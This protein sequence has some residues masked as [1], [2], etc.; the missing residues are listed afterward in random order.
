[1]AR[2]LQLRLWLKE[3]LNHSVRFP[4]LVKTPS[5]RHLNSLFSL[6]FEDIDVMCVKEY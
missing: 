3:A 1:M 5:F 6:C 2:E 4:V